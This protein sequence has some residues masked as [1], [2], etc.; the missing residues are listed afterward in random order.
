MNINPVYNI[1]FR[2]KIKIVSP[3]DFDL[4]TWKLSRS[5]EIDEIFKLML[6][7]KDVYNPSQKCYRTN[8]DVV[9]TIG[10]RSCT[11]GVFSNE[12]NPAS[13]VMHIYDC[14][15]NFERLSE[16]DSYIEGKNAFLIGSREEYPFSQ[17]VFEFFKDKIT[18]KNIPATIFEGFNDL[19]EANFIHLANSD[20][21]IVCIKDI[22][23]YKRYVKNME[24]LKQAFKSVVISSNDTIEFVTS[25]VA[26]AVCSRL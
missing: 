9:A 12:Q 25:K 8:S 23:N 7:P 10:V 11:A 20:E 22:L 24:E 13:L 15:D 18:T 3:E 4:V 14:K 5:G 26:K 6:N 16:L 17:K 1:N 19:W 21:I 2:S